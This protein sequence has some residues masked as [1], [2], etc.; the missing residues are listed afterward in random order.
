MVE[1]TSQITRLLAAIGD[2]EKGATDRLLDLV[3]DHL[4][5]LAAGRMARER[6]DHTLQATALVN[7]AYLKLFGAEEVSWKDRGHFFGVAAKAMRRILINHARDRGRQKRGGGRP[8]V[9]L[10]AL[11]LTAEQGSAELLA[12]DEALGQ[13]EKQDARMARI[14]RLRFYAGRSI[15]ETAAALDLSTST[16]KREWALAR[17][18]LYQAL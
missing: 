6:P 13:L 3:H 15:E 18:W 7:E 11:E 14:V 9:G 8:R 2:G 12:L 17:A 5:R 10:T 1:S 4:H 16:V